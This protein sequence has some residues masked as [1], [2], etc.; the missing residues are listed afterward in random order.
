MVY[1]RFMKVCRIHPTL[2]K[3]G[4]TAMYKKRTFKREVIKKKNPYNDIVIYIA[5]IY[6]DESLSE[7]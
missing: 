3:I 4:E 1:F 5:H 7:T 6:K 2:I